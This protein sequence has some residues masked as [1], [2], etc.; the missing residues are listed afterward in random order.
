[1]LRRDFRVARVVRARRR[2]V[3]ERRRRRDRHARRVSPR[4]VHEDDGRHPRD[5]DVD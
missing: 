3:P 5:D 2:E 4:R 1:M